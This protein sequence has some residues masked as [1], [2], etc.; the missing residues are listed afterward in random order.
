MELKYMTCPKVVR[1]APPIVLIPANRDRGYYSSP[2]FQNQF[3]RI[4]IVVATRPS[5]L[6]SIH[7]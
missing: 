4:Y 6:L 5:R 7:Y 3:T 2:Y 1:L